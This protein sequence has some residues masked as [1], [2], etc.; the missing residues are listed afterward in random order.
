MKRGAQ[1]EYSLAASF[2]ISATPQGSMQEQ[3][4]ANNARHCMRLAED[5]LKENDSENADLA[6]RNA[7]ILFDKSPTLLPMKWHFQLGWA[8]TLMQNKSSFESINHPRG[9]Q[10]LKEL[11][12]AL[13]AAP[14]EQCLNQYQSLLSLYRWLGYS[15]T[16]QEL[17]YKMRFRMSLCGTAS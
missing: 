11:E 17:E 15:K 14:V 16:L 7:M 6:Y 9:L 2:A 10:I 12:A 5:F 3:M 4:L 13:D 1:L 8:H